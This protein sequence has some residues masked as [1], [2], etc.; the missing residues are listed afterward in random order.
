MINKINVE[1]R[2]T[3]MMVYLRWTDV[4]PGVKIGVNDIISEIKKLSLVQAVELLSRIENILSSPSDRVYDIKT[5]ETILNILFEFNYQIIADKFKAGK[6]NVIFHHQ[7]VLFLMNLVIAFGVIDQKSSVITKNEV[8]DLLL[9]V[10]N[11]L[12]ENIDSDKLNKDQLTGILWQKHHVNSVFSQDFG[13]ELSRMYEILFNKRYDFG[14]DQLFKRENNGLDIK[15]YWAILVSIIFHWEILPEDRGK[16]YPL[17]FNPQIWFKNAKNISIEEV[18]AVLNLLSDNFGQ[19][20]KMILGKMKSL[21][22]YPVNFEAFLEKPILKIDDE[23]YLCLSL[24]HLIYAAGRGI[25]E[26]L[27]RQLKINNKELSIVKSQ[28]FHE[29]IKKTL[30]MVY[31]DTGIFKRL[32]SGKSYGIEIA[33]AVIVYNDEL[34]F[35]ETKTT[36]IKKSDRMTSNLNKIE[37]ALNGYFVKEGFAQ[38]DKRI[39]DFKNG[40]IKIGDIDPKSI[41]RYWPVLISCIDDIPSNGILR[42][43]FLNILRESGALISTDISPLTI[44]SL[45][46]FDYI[47]NQLLNGKS[48]LG[49]LKDWNSTF[50]KKA[51]ELCNYM[52]FDEPLKESCFPK[53]LEKAYEGFKKFVIDELGLDNKI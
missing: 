16:D 50:E 10:N 1:N 4:Y 45:K 13:I 38:L 35:I 12:D 21:K 42:T 2:L 11:I 27:R 31:P 19:I 44:L 3:G 15:K 26:I 14:L 9:K 17:M 25:F 36:I 34:I 51:K 5:Q 52:V 49:I 39:A 33:D 43:Y 32:Y 30:S 6:F 41:V 40:T 28:I 47:I 37:S 20:K 48:F 7:Q 18:N 46:E 23:R 24:T 22:N 8:G 29:Y 53:H